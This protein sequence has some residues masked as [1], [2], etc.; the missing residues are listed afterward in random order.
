MNTQLELLRKPIVY[1]HHTKTWTTSLWIAEEFHR[2]HDNVV[3]DIRKLKCSESFR[4]LNF[5]ER[6]YVGD[7]G[8]T[9]PMYEMT[10][11]G[12]MFL[13][14]GYHGR[15]AAKIKEAYIHEFD[16]R[17]A[18]LIRQKQ[19]DWL[20]VRSQGKQPRLIEATAIERFADY[21][22]AQGSQHAEQYFINITRETYRAL[23]DVHPQEMK[24][25]RALLTKPQLIVLQMAE[26]LISE[27]LTK[28]MIA[29]LP[30]KGEGGIFDRAMKRIREFAQFIG[31]SPVPMLEK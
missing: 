28:G 25:I 6:D 18:A 12:F 9:Y 17:G 13:V 20:D 7:R 19:L 21:A 5:E 16:R 4:L 26:T 29:N 10:F 22:R 30:Y 1:I 23:F 31:K 8:K 2:R 11:N 3:R 14:M 15:Q 27:E 24:R